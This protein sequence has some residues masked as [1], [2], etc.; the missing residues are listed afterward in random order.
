MK[1]EAFVRSVVAVDGSEEQIFARL[2]GEDSDDARVTV[3]RY[4]V[5]ERV[6]KRRKINDIVYRAADY[7]SGDRIDSVG[8]KEYDSESGDRLDGVRRSTSDRG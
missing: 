5:D 7:A 4:P 2:L 8:R 1:D 3:G 6:L